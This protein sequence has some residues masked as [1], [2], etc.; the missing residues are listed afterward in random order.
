M[1]MEILQIEHRICTCCMEVHDVKRVRF[2]DHT[3]FKDVSVDCLTEAFYCD[4]A[5]EFYT[6]IL[7]LY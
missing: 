1:N 6:T 2:M 5:E 7:I 3:T 4:L